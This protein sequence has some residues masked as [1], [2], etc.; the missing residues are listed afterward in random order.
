MFIKESVGKYHW[1]YK[2]VNRYLDLNLPYLEKAIWN[3][4]I[5][6]ATTPFYILNVSKKMTFD[7]LILFQTPI[8]VTNSISML[9]ILKYK[10][11]TPWFSY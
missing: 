11:K 7:L 3:F 1:Y 4:S 6:N 9:I 5:F 8:H 10:K 2:Q